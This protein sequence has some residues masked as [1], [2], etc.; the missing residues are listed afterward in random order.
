MTKP[1]P[2]ASTQPRAA[3]PVAPNPFASKSRKPRAAKSTAPKP[4]MAETPLPSPAAPAEAP[5]P[6]TKLGIL[7]AL[8]QRKEGATVT[9]MMAATGWQA[10]SVRGALAGTLAKKFGAKV[11][12]EL[13]DAV[14]IYRAPS[15]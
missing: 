6:T 3:K 15:V 11:T 13:E 1:K 2:Q 5:A 4:A 9:Q 12:S 7:T 14:R 8:L 10:H